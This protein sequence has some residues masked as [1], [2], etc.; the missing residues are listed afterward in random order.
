MYFLRVQILQFFLLLVLFPI[1]SAGAKAQIAQIELRSGSSGQTITDRMSVHTSAEEISPAQAWSSLLESEK[2]GEYYY[3]FIQDYVWGGFSLENPQDVESWIIEVE[4]PHLSFIEMFTKQANGNWRLI[5]STGRAAPFNTRDVEHTNF[6]FE[7]TVPAGE[8]V[9]VLLML[10]KRRSSI[11][12]PVTVWGA[13]DFYRAQQRNYAYYGVYFGFFV[14]VVL[15]SFI[16]FFVSFKRQFLWY[17]LYVLSVGLFV[18]NDLG[19]AQKYIYPDSATIGGH[20]RLGITYVMMIALNLFTISYFRT[21]ELYPA[22]HMIILSCCAIIG[23]I[24]FA[25]IAFTEFTITHATKIIVTLYA[26]ILGSIG[27]AIGAGIRFY[28]VEK[29]SSLLFIS[30]FSFIFAAGILF[31]L[32]EFG[33]IALPSMLFTPIQIASVFEITFLSVGIAW[34]I[35]IAEK[36]RLKLNDEVARLENENLRSF[37]KGTEKERSRVAMDLHDAVGSRLS[38]LSRNVDSRR[39]DSDDIKTELKIVLRDVRNISHKLSPPGLTLINLTSNIEVMIDEYNENGSIL[40]AFQ[41][42]NI[43][44]DLAEETAAQIYRIVQE[45]VEN[46]EKHSRAN[47]AEIQLIQYDDQL[48]LTIEDDGDGFELNGS[49][50]EGI[51]LDNI[52]KRVG[53]FGGDLSISSRPGE[54]TQILI[55]IPLAK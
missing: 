44:E 18:F 19:L 30:A 4:N 48:V 51:G 52:K 5:G 47:H 25:H 14:I 34:Q 7:L 27:A 54:G 21:K 17:F 40:Y 15:V 23:S 39:L 37:I 53:Y 29:Y 45:G 1:I 31:I 35:R 41:T 36:Q 8:R 6:A 3:G 38:Q 2:I 20:A 9:D 11:Q 26:A 43:D 28:K 22:I 16:A 46:I 49:S 10:D 50:T 55:T 33:I 24:A 42:L 32:S 13:P 12:Y